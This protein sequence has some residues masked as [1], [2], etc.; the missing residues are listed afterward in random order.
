MRPRS[1]IARGLGYYWR[2]HL[3]VVI[4]VATAVAV[5][6][7]ALLVGDSVRAS[8]R[9]LVLQRL[10]N[11][12]D[13]VVSAN[14]FREALAQGVA[15]HPDF[16]A[17]FR[18]V[19]PLV[20]VQGFVTDQ[21]S[22]RRAGRVLVYGVDERFWRFHDAAAVTAIADR[23][24][25]VSPALAREIGAA[26]DRAILVRVQ[27]PSDIPL[28][29]LH[30]RKDDVGR[31]MRLTVREVLPP[32][33]LGE[34]A[35][36]PAQGDVRAVF[37]PLARLQ[38][39][40]EVGARVNALLVRRATALGDAASGDL[41]AIVRDTATLEDV[42]ITLT[43]GDD[44]RTIVVGSTAGLL[45]PR[46]VEA[47]EQALG[48]GGIRGQPVFT[49][50]A[51]TLRAGDREIPYSLV[52]A[53]S[54][55][56]LATAVRAGSRPPAGTAAARASR[57]P[58]DP[59]DILLTEWAARDLQVAPGDRVSL[60]YY[61]WTDGGQL[62]TRSADFRLA[63]IVPTGAGSRDL[64]PTFPGLSDAPSLEDWDPPFP[65][66]LSRVRPVDEQYWDDYRTTPKAF[67]AYEAGR[68]LWRSRF[69]EMTSI[70]VPAADAAAAVRERAA[71]ATRLRDSVDP[72]ALGLTVRAVRA[73]GM[74]ASRGATDFGQY[75]VYFS[76]FLVVSALLLVSLFFKLGIEQRAREVG[77]LRAVGFD[78]AAVRRLF[79]GEGAV[80]A[81][82]GSALGLL[83]AVGYA[84]LIMT[85]LGT[86]WVDAV[87]TTAL[88]LHV[89]AASLLA[90]AGGGML[91]ALVCIWWTLRS[92]RRVSERSL[93]AGQ[94]SLADDE[95]PT[96]TRRNARLAAAIALAA[97]GAGL[98]AGAA[99]GVVPPAGAFFGAG[100]SMLAA[101][102]CLF[103]WA[104]RRHPRHVVAGHGWR[105][106][107]RLGIR[108]ATY[109]PGR[110]VVSA[111][112]IA[113]ATFLLIAVDA[114]RRDGAQATADP[115]SGIG[116]Y[117][118]FV[119]T[120]LPVAYDPGAGTADPLNL[121][122]AVAPAK[123][124]AFRLLP[125]D[126]ASCLNLYAPANPRIVS[127][128][129][130]FLRAA[131]FT[132]QGSLAATDAERENPWLLLLR[133]EPDGAIPVIAD[134]NSMTYVL[135]R[136]LGE[137]IVIT[138]N[139]REI[140]LRL[141]AALR[142]SLFQSELVMGRANFQSLFADQ[143]G[144]RVFLIDAA[145]DRT[146]AVVAGV[147]DAL[148]E[149]GADAMPTAER[150]AAFHRVENTYLSTFQTLGGLG[151]LLGTVG[152]AT[153]LLRNAL[154]RRKE[155]ALL[156]AVGFRR[157]H[158]G[159]MVLAEN[160]V[161]LAVGL[162]AG[163]AAASLAIAPAVAARGGRWPLTSGGLL[164]LF[165]VFVAGVLS[166]AVAARAVTRAPLL[167]S[168]RSE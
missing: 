117:Q 38:A 106:V 159:T 120:E 5:L 20:M 140:R 54:L 73:E 153:V 104:L 136:A 52:T 123:W 31:T 96:A 161:L 156:G 21:E 115:K 45:E 7:G 142:D 137:D 26:A 53:T 151:L 130:E 167:A 30:G 6:A 112:V 37:M 94:V 58:N 24:A 86:W 111:A 4:G 66:D 90:G 129:D 12:D 107:S 35:L 16:T 59:H 149:Y 50:L 132:F 14:F 131:R 61:L 62:V 128:R 36:D 51:N 166:S 102:L 91:A 57:S 155:L 116:G 154:E 92:L 84:W 69:G 9:D 99:A 163:A 28:D 77:L 164:L 13:V 22:G 160:L 72:L 75:F 103:G 87:G 64:V 97:V 158:F 68:D 144:Y 135:H 42:G 109:R 15:A 47:I 147:E 148:A 113:S 124:E 152:L 8:L 143:E 168:L 19:A 89:S 133:A 134:A 18:A 71:L 101:C 10:G 2:T 82:L 55:D 65:I 105:P 41:A 162:L 127:P 49:Y 67:V 39:E 81:G 74:S 145:P 119:E 1:L 88:S 110:S 40:L 139:G 60:E 70:R 83:G 95:R 44:G 100:A 114:F 33:R 46:Q 138:R 3:A 56:G 79:L 93:L 157:G 126:D 17:R 43:V 34:F 63:G 11:T 80:L 118:V 98:V 121:A 85:G 122:A 146:N 150:L 32:S 141:V 108:N 48:A 76:F 25:Y 165:A 125:G 23:E 27:R 78:T 29:S